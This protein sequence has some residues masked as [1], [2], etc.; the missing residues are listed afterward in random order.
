M[1]RPREDR[2]AAAPEHSR[3]QAQLSRGPL[4]D[5][6]FLRAPRVVWMADSPTLWGR[7]SSL[8]TPMSSFLPTM[9]CGRPED[10]S[11]DISSGLRSRFAL[12]SW[13]SHFP[14]CCFCFPIWQWGLGMNELSALRGWDSPL[15]GESSVPAEGARPWGADWRL[16]WDHPAEGQRARVR[17]KWQFHTD[18]GYPSDW[19]EGQ[20]P[21]KKELCVRTG[22][23]ASQPGPGLMAIR[24]QTAGIQKQLFISAQRSPPFGGGLC[25]WVGVEDLS[26]DPSPYKT[27]FK[28]LEKRNVASWESIMFYRRFKMYHSYGI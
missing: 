15:S 9:V 24:N 12:C 16:P 26:P 8:A 13:R 18:L 22:R 23:L 6:E 25:C 11:E 4:P 2:R 20:A 19:L 21:Q 17:Q 7:G 5:G 3:G 27:I 10:G 14:T 1:R 28:C